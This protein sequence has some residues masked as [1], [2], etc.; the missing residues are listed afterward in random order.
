MQLLAVF[1]HKARLDI[2]IDDFADDFARDASI[3]NL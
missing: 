2:A 1:A 3:D